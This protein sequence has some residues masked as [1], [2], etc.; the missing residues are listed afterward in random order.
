[1]VPTNPGE[2]GNMAVKTDC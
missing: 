2:P 1:M